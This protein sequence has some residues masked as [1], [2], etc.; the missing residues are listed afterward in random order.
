MKVGLVLSQP[1]GH[2]L[3]TDGR[4]LGLAKG[5]DRLGVEVHFIT[6][7]RE[8]I[9]PEKITVN[10]FSS[11][12]TKLKIS[13]LQYGVSKKLLDNR[14][15]CRKMLSRKF[16][17]MKH[18]NSLGQGVYK[19]AKRLGLDILQGEQQM[20]SMACVKVGERLDL[21]VVADF[22]G[23]WAEEMVASGLIEQDGSSYRVLFDLE[24]EIACCA[25]AVTV[26]S[27]EMKNY[28]ENSFAVP[29]AKVVL[30][31]NATFPRV[32]NAK[33]V[34][35]PS[36]VIHSGTLH[37]W[38]NVELFV[39]AMPFILKHY[40]S[41]KFYLTR[42]G[43][44]L[45]KIVGLAGK[46]GVFPEFIW[47]PNN[48]EFFDL[49]KSCDVGVISSTTHRARKMAYPAKLYDYLSAGLPI[50]ANDVGA[51]TKLISENRLGIV[52]DN[53]PEALADGILEFLQSPELIHEC[54]QRG[55]KI[56]REKLNYY[57]SAGQL[58]D[59]YCRML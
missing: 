59:L 26:V 12:K 18:A 32:E 28:I 1:F 7:F 51:W 16:F 58:L 41:A 34:E 42:K 56:V 23:I 4:I 48:E 50:V 54:G 2:S 29:S 14:F 52:T 11:L 9:S 13:N 15:L 44:K 57:K 45:N 33:V 10:E 38:E 17:L 39:Q 55:I 24:Q 3:G 47:L 22:H 31:P 20:A 30:V 25:N 6:P 43:A 8:G 49:L 35:Q 19:V 37:P 36:K 46:L 40:P 5:L 27:E 53:T 21:P